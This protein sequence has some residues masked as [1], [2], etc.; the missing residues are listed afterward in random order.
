MIDLYSG[1]MRCVDCG[2]RVVQRLR[3]DEVDG[4]ERRQ[5]PLRH[6][7][8]C[9]ALTY[10]ELIEW[11]G[12]PPVSRRTDRPPD[13]ILLIDDDE[14]TVK[15]LRKVLE[16]EN[17]DLEVA[18]DGRE[19]LQKLMEQRYALVV[20]DLHMPNLDGKKL[21]KF[22]DD[23]ALESRHLLLFITGDTTPETRQFLE[24]TGCAYL[25]KPLP[26]LRFASIVRDMI[27]ARHAG[28]GAD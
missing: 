23:H 9:L 16:G 15:M 26:L 8:F 4:L 28:E 17:C 21:F 11:K 18:S 27:E 14:L 10:W 12:K 13:R 24:G 19:G 20:C 3:P 1:L 5:L 6:C 2:L 22:L 7:E 25:H